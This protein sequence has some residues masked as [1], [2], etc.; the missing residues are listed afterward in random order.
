LAATPVA[1]ARFHKAKKKTCNQK[2]GATRLSFYY[3]R[4]S[5]SAIQQEQKPH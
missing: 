2:E 3:V 5:R 1:N 4:L